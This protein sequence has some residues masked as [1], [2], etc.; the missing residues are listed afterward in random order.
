M[1]ALLSQNL[2][3]I[4]SL[5]CALPMKGTARIAT[6]RHRIGG[7]L[8]AFSDRFG[9]A[10]KWQSN[11][12]GFSHGRA[13]LAWL[14]DGYDIESALVCAYTC[15]T[16]PAFMR[17]KGL[18]IGFFDIGAD[19]QKVA[20]IAA[21][22]PAPCVAL[23]PALFGMPPWIDAR[24]LQARL[25][26]AS[27][28]VIDAAQTAFGHADFN[29]PARGAVLSCPRKSTSLPDGA[30]LALGKR[31]RVG[32]GVARL[33]TADAPA[34]MKAAARAIWAAGDVKS[35]SI[36]IRYS[37]LSEKSW[38]DAP[39]RMS[40][41]SLAL[42][43]KL[44]R[45]WHVAR[46]RRNRQVLAKLLAGQVALWKSSDGVP[47]NLPIFV[48]NRGATLAALRK[49]RI[50]A[51]ALWPDAKHDPK[52]HPLASWMARH[53]ISLPV[54]QR[55][56]EADMRRVADAVLRV[57]QPVAIPSPLNQWITAGAT[58]RSA[59]HRRSGSGR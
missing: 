14:L 59:R 11:W 12:L 32:A 39:H 21:T 40:G 13:A 36:A 58:T 26:A 53:L 29:A 3:E 52:R 30:V 16:V 43:K 18:P 41:L 42:L 1:T 27:L 51:S 47:F 44:D 49:K 46:R 9:D 4:P 17:R 35:E 37:H 2:Q 8:P 45:T 55:H 25:P 24:R 57:A 33:P 50:F 6:A 38:P 34:A 22:L 56:D 20:E 23:L 48:R 28:I 5:A 10:S 31:L 7:E 19:E 54:D 15:P